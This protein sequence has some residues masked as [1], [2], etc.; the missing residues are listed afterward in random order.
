MRQVSENQLA[1]SEINCRVRATWSWAVL[2]MRKMAAPLQP[3]GRL[4]ATCMEQPEIRML[5]ICSGICLSVKQE[6]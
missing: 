6:A 3:E 1:N 2:H 4:W 5:K